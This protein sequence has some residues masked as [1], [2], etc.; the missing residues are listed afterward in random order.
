[1]A[2][3]A[4]LPTTPPTTVPTGPAALPINAPVPAPAHAPAAAPA[5]PVASFATPRPDTLPN[6]F[7]FSKSPCSFVSSPF[8]IFSSRA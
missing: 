4:R 1:M 5:V 8:A 2:P 3:P 6:N 7:F